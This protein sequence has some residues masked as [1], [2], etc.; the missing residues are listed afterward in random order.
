MVCTGG[1]KANKEFANDLYGYNCI[2]KYVECVAV[3]CSVLQCVA[4]CCSVLQCVAVKITS[5]LQTALM[6]TRTSKSTYNVLR[7]VAVC[8]SVL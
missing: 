8:C 2:P 6:D 4:V 5:S 7:C 1:A 3:C